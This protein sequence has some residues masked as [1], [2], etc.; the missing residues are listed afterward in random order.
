[1]SQRQPA[2]LDSR[3][4][5]LAYGDGLFETMRV[6]ADGTIPLQALHLQRLG[7]GARALAIPLPNQAQ[8]QQALNQATSSLAGP[9]LIKLILTRGT[10]GRGYLP[11][12]SATP[13]LLWQTA[14][15]PAWSDND[16]C[17]GIEMGICSQPLFPDPFA[18]QKHL[19]RLAQVQSRAEVA[20]QGWQEGLMLSARRQPLEATAMNLFARFKTGWWTPDLAL[21]NAGVAGV[22]REWLL[23]QLRSRGESVH[24]DLRPLSQLR[25]AEAVFLTNSVVGVLPV[26]KLA[27]WRWGVPD[28]VLALQAEVDSLFDA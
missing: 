15:L 7:R 23:T 17:H 26:R 14:D 28:T 27:Q 25:D 11:P 5:G 4:R 16:R 20:R 9:G 13:S 19:N 21:A 8:L 22:M 10:G 24:C 2:M 12:A 18:G 6:A 1:M 3:D